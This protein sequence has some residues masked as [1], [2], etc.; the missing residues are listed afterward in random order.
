MPGQ[1]SHIVLNV[2]LST[3]KAEHENPMVMSPGHKIFTF[4][5][6]VGNMALKKSELIHDTHMLV[7]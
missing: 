1:L 4:C 7:T 6:S 3:S 5:R 2:S